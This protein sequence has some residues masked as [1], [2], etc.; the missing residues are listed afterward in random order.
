VVGLVRRRIRKRMG[1][2]ESLPLLPPLPL[3]SQGMVEMGHVRSLLLLQP[4]L[5]GL[6]VR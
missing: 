3:A 5:V 4:V 2:G 6:V 1:R